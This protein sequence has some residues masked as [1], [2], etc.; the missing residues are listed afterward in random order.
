MELCI[1]QGGSYPP[2]PSRPHNTFLSISSIIEEKCS[3][4]LWQPVKA[5]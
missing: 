2:P 1:D 5:S 4:K 3:E